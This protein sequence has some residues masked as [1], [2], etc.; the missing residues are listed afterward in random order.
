MCERMNT[1]SVRLR[2]NDFLQITEPRNG[3]EWIE[4]KTDR[5]ST[6]PKIITV[7]TPKQSEKIDAIEHE[8]ERE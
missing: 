3:T 8:N 4:M 7:I 5:N 1:E 6:T 2:N